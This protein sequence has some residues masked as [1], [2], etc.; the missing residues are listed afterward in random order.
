LN[1]VFCA[2]GTCNG[3]GETD[4]LGLPDVTN[5]FKLFFRLNGDP[6]AATLALA[7]EQEATAKAADGSITQWSKYID[8]VGD[9]NNPLIQMLGGATGAGLITRVVRGYTFISRVYNPGDSIYLVGF[10]RGAYTVRALAG[11]ILHSGLLNRNSY[12]P[13]DVVQAYRYGTGAWYAYQRTVSIQRNELGILDGLLLNLP[14]FVTTPPPAF[15]PNVPIRAIGVWDT[16][17]SYGFSAA[18]DSTGAKADLLPLANT[19]LDLRVGNGFQAISLDEQRD[20]FVPILW[21]QAANV[22][23]C[24]FP[25]A[26]ADVG[27]GYPISGGQAQLSDIALEWMIDRLM[28][29]GADIFPS[30][31]FSENPNPGGIA[32]QQWRY[33]PWRA[34]NNSARSFTGRADLQVHPS[35]AQRS[36]LPSVISDPGNQSGLEPII[37]ITGPYAPAN[38][39]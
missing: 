3:P 6:T 14:S 22:Q 29:A 38:L 16:V 26:H 25:G 27:G 15:V 9:S 1:I 13:T 35:I 30:G 2:D 17:S 8:G 24:L 5:V 31:E 39:P 28:S 4:D 7:Q 32:H 10:S 11:L 34:L 36:A 12:D 21:D 33:L 19:Q 37:P 18:Y 20:V 23:Q